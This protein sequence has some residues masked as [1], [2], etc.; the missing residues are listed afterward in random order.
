ME[1]GVVVTER[2]SQGRQRLS[3]GERRVPAGQVPHVVAWK[4]EVVPP[5]QGK[6]NVLPLKGAKVSAGQGRQAR[7]VWAPETG[8]KVPT[9]GQGVQEVESG[10]SEKVPAGHRLHWGPSR[11]EPG[12]HGLGDSEETGEKSKKAARGRR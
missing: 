12:G 3:R 10:S 6:Q 1:F 8:L 5:G 7:A 11:K 4:A 2:P 9:A